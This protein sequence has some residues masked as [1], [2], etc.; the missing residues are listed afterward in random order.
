M[1]FIPRGHI[2]FLSKVG[3]DITKS[4]SSSPNNS[5]IKCKFLIMAFKKPHALSPASH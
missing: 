4:F 5:G 3:N 1:F 2:T